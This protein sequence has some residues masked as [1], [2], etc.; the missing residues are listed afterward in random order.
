MRA[1]IGEDAPFADFTALP[2]ADKARLFRSVLRCRRVAEKV[3]LADEEL[4]EDPAP[5]MSALRRIVALIPKSPALLTAMAT[6]MSKTRG[7]GFEEELFEMIQLA[8]KAELM[9]EAAQRVS[10]KPE[11]FD[12]RR[13]RRL[14]RQVEAFLIY[15]AFESVGIPVPLTGSS[16]DLGRTAHPGLAMAARL[17][18]YTSGEK[19]TPNAFR[20]RL[21]RYFRSRRSREQIK[22]KVS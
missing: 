20:K 21:Y 11:R 6:Q 9:L 7:T 13:M 5:L 17:V 1:A 22:K 19:I 10:N 15:K 3:N 8:D 2:D 18:A 4:T 12:R 14:R 16:D